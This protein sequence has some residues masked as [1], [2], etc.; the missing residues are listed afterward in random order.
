MLSTRLSRPSTE[1]VTRTAPTSRAR[2]SHL[3]P[4]PRKERVEQF[5]KQDAW[6]HYALSFE[7]LFSAHRLLALALEERRAGVYRLPGTHYTS[8]AIGA[9]T[10]VA[11]AFDGFLTEVCD[12]RRQRELAAASTTME[13]F[14]ELLP[15]GVQID[16]A[17][18]QK[19]V[20]VRNEIVH[21]LPRP[22]PNSG[23]VA[24]VLEDLDRRGLLMTTPKTPSWEVP[25]R[26]ASYALAYWAFET[27]ET[28]LGKL[29]DVATREQQTSLLLV[30]NFSLYRQWACPPAS[31][32]EYDR[33]YG[34]SLTEQ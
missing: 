2:Y 29:V 13:R 30:H 12:F 24:D 8:F 22:L 23:C 10:L 31:L 5:I 15:H 34:L 17:D 28:A 27:I 26:L 1:E 19:L 14:A 20:V 16:T 3:V 6:G 18:L 4:S 32:P 21:Y 7:L 9:I 25:Q 33:Q 11:T